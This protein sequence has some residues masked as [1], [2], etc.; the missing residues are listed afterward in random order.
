MYGLIAVIKNPKN[1]PTTSGVYFFKNPKGKILYIGK[2]ANLKNRLVFYLKKNITNTRIASMLQQAVKLAWQETDSEV[3]ALI[4]ESRSIK[5]HRPPFNILMRDDKQYFYV[6]FT[7]EKFPKIFLTHQPLTL[8]HKT[9]IGPFT[10]GTAL[11]TTLKL[12]RKTFP[13]CTCKEKHNNYCL[14]YHL[15]NC[16]GFCCLK[17][18]QSQT[19]DKKSYQKNIRSIKD[20]LSGKRMSLSKKM[21][22]EMQQAAKENDFIKAIAIRNKLRELKWIF[23]NAKIIKQLEEKDKT[24][25]EVQ[26]FFGLPVLPRRIEAFDI[27][28]IQGQFAV[29]A[30]AVFTDGQPYMAESPGFRPDKSQYRKFKIKHTRSGGDIAMLKEILSRRLKHREWP[31]PDLIIIGLLSR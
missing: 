3:E 14:N 15:D 25:K 28:N 9:L 31:L 18:D 6:V 16:P 27:S 11:K 4:L 13:Y 20:I 17:V 24:L 1:I 2:A 12:L 19:K 26:N 7:K 22:K 29:G 8:P 30:M 21:E 10:D 5:K 23:E